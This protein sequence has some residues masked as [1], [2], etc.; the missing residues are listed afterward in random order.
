[1]SPAFIKGI[2]EE[3]PLS[4][5]IFDKFHIIKLVNEAVNEVRRLEQVL[6]RICNYSGGSQRSHILKIFIS[7]NITRLLELIDLHRKIL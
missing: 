2:E 5:I 6:N 7:S 4:S 3:F 1:M